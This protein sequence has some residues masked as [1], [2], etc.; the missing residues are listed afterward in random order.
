MAVTPTQPDDMAALKAVSARMGAD[1]LLIQS[2]GGNTSVKDGQ[3]MWIKASGTLLSDAVSGEIFVPVDLLAMRTALVED[4]PDADQPAKFL[5]MDGALRPSIETSLHAVFEHR[6][7]LH[8]HCVNTIAQAIRQDAEIVLGDRLS[9]LDWAFVDYTKPGANLAR[10]V[11]GKLGPN[12]DVV[13]LGNHGLLVA[14]KT[15]EAARL[16]ISDVVARLSVPAAWDGI[17]DI[18]ALD[19]LGAGSDYE[20]AEDTVSHQLAMNLWRVKAATI[21]SL[22]PD[23]VIFCGIGATAVEPDEAVT[24]ASDRVIASGMSVPVF[25]IVPG[26]GVLLRKGISDGARAL[27]RCLADVLIRVP[28]HTPLNYLTEAQNLELLDWD[29]EKY[30]QSLNAGNTA[31][32]G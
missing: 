21:G 12:T 18:A 9:G 31:N 28:D 25:L 22:Y 30:R 3:T 2:A 27:V 17:P 4:R 1:P 8:V 24:A 32:A 23:H 15:V 5:L 7:V 14:G 29:A 10:Q 20:P 16:K 26:K 6:A 11:R 13:V 19:S